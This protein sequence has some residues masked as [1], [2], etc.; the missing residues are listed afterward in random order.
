[1][2]VL[3]NILSKLRRND[4]L[5]VH[6][7]LAA[8]DQSDRLTTEDVVEL[9]EAL[10]HNTYLKSL[11]V[12]GH[13]LTALG[14]KAL[15]Q[16]KIL[17]TL[18]AK[19]NDIGM[20]GL[21]A[22]LKNEKLEHLDISGNDFKGTQRDDDGFTSLD[23][24]TDSPPMNQPLVDA[25]LHN[26]TCK[27]LNMSHMLNADGFYMN[28]HQLRSFIKSNI[29]LRSIVFDFDLE[30]EENRQALAKNYTLITINA[31]S[32]TQAEPVQHPYAQVIQNR[33]RALITLLCLMLHAM[34]PSK[35]AARVMG[36]I[37][38]LRYITDF[39]L[40]AEDSKKPY[41]RAYSIFHCDMEVMDR[42]AKKIKTDASDAAS[43]SSSGL[44]HV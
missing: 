20:Y 11:D 36:N 27:A 5:L 31:T 1:M 16:S 23:F 35:K 22:L 29:T 17:T 38:L 37:D 6:L 24:L 9:C 42:P 41:L 28:D 4:P 15:A 3:P 39:I 44:P 18:I 10:A 26:K 13:R 12:S 43:G 7:D 40:P 25:L 14:A 33:N 2:P 32:A 30:Q 8:S 19:H 21:V 34:K